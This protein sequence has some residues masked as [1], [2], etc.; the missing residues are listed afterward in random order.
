[1]REYKET[2]HSLMY[3]SNSDMSLYSTGYEECSPG[4]SYGPKI[5]SYHMIHFVFAGKGDV[6]INEHI[7]HLEAGDAFLIPAGKVSYYEADKNDPWHYAWINFLGIN[8]HMYLSQLMTS[9]DGIYVIHSL[10]TAKYRTLIMDMLSVK[11]TSTSQYFQT[12]GMLYQIMAML[13]QDIGFQENSWGKISV[14]DEIKFYLDMNYAE[15]I[16]LRD[17]SQKYGLHPNYLTRTF[18]EK[19]GVSPKQYMMNLKLKKACRLL[20]TTELNIAVISSSLGFD[21]QFAFAKCFKKA[22]AVSP[23][24]YRKESRKSSVSGITETDEPCQV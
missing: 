7:F 8:S 20:T 4:Y 15:K 1:M 13:F 24:D 17:V 22:Y 5:R 14:I 16:K 10:D 11:G 9:T 19:Y 21:D 3:K 2:Y 12:T 23:S 6:R 18:H